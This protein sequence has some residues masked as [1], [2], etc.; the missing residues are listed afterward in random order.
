MLGMILLQ[1]A[2][3]ASLASWAPVSALVSP[4]LQQ[5]LVLVRSVHRR[6]MP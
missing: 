2:A 4:L 6:W 1:A 3:G 5:V